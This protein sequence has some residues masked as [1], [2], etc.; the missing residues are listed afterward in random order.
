LRDHKYELIHINVSG[1]EH[2]Q[3]FVFDRQRTTN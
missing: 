2:W 1:S 3:I